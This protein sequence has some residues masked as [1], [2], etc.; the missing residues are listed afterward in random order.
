MKNR[1]SIVVL[2]V[3]I[4]LLVLS[5]LGLRKHA[6]RS[7]LAVDSAVLLPS[8]VDSDR[9][10]IERRDRPPVELLRSS[11]WRLV[12]PY[13]GS[14]DGQAV[15]KLLDILSFT[16]VLDV[17]DDS[18]L[19]KLGHSRA[20]FALSDPALKVTV[21]GKG[22]SETLSFGSLTSSADGVYATASR[23]D[24]VFVVPL[25]VLS[26]VDGPSENFRQRALFR[27]AARDIRSFDIRL[28]TGSTLSFAR[29]GDAWK[30][31]EERASSREIEKFIDALVSAQAVD[32]LWPTSGTNETAQVSVALLAGYGLEPESAV[33]VIVK[34]AEEVGASVSFG[35]AASDGK[36]YAAIQN[37]SAIVTVPAALKEVA[38]RSSTLF[39]DSRLFPF[40]MS[41][42]IRVSL[43]DGGQTYA[44]AR[45]KENAWSLESPIVAPADASVVERMIRRLSGLTTADVVPSD[46][47]VSVSL[48]TNMP[49]VVV[50]RANVLGEDRPDDLR[51]REIVRID[52]A[53]VKRLVRT[54]AGPRGQEKSASVVFGRDRKAWNVESSEEGEVARESEIASVLAALNPLTALRVEKLKVSA[55]DLDD[56]GLD[57]PFLS[58]AIDQ[59]LDDAVR[60]NV[61]VGG[62]TVGGRFATVGS[63]DA[64]FVI[65]D[66]V[67]KRLSSAIVGR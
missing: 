5:N 11:E 52:P 10:F 17:I 3:L 28:G 32:F 55:S 23:V 58:L 43:S 36:V 34:G 8:A 51:A 25:A 19:L 14:A 47:G 24:S 49:P 39:T 65:S 50:S 16:R 41:E 12:S 59:D 42:I 13:A 63:S 64:V 53:R 56:F 18:E 27:L 67:V 21:S 48:V 45:G 54:S 31:G 57:K 61:L 37:D 1:K 9:V 29:E 26:A 46:A 30:A 44:L 33:T 38:V 35:K 4:V 15:A 62:K 22:G 40:D 2:S 6:A 20:D 66:E 60:R 7:R